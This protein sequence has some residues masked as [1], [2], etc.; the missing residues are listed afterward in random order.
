MPA[1]WLTITVRRLLL[2][3]KKSRPKKLT[4]PSLRLPIEKAETAEADNS[5]SAEKADFTENT[6]TEQ[7]KGAEYEL[8]KANINNLLRGN[9]EQNILI[10]S[11]DIVQIPQSDVFFVAGEVKTPGSF[12][13]KE[14]T[15]VRQAISL[16]QGTNFEGNLD[17]SIIFREDTQTGKRQEIKIDVGA[18]MAGKK[19]DVAILAN[20]I[21]IV[22]NS[23]KKTVAKSLLKTFSGGLPRLLF[24]F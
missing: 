19:E 11:G 5:A 1:V 12:P 15:T 7:E 16:A 14:G 6:N 21:I 18:I 13:L 4:P 17:Q 20:D 10:E 9:F 24:G 23:K 22:P 2:C 3:G 8:V